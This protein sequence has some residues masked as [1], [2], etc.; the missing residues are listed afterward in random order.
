MKVAQRVGIVSSDFNEKREKAKYKNFGCTYVI[1]N[2]HSDRI[3]CLCSLVNGAFISGSSDKTIK[4]W[5][6]LEPKPIG[7]LEEDE[8]VTL[9]L[10]LGKTAQND[11]TMLY[12]TKQSIKFLSLKQGK[13]V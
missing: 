10:R 5:S 6:P 11:I 9:M 13:A 12:V 1:R 4:V 8:E 3:N 2:A 7:V